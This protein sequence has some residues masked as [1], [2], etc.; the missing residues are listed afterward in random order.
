MYVCT[1]CALVMDQVSHHVQELLVKQAGVVDGADGGWGVLVYH[2]G[3]VIGPCD[4]QLFCPIEGPETNNK[5]ITTPPSVLLFIITHMAETK[6]KLNT[7][8]ID[9]LQPFMFL[10]YH[11][12][13]GEFL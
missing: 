11:M 5:R 13:N 10:G 7:I 6:R 8:E 2:I 9:I 3:V 12:I 1:M 4:D